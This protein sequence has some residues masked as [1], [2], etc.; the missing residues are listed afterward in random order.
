MLPTPLCFF[1]LIILG[2]KLNSD[3]VCPMR[4]WT[5]SMRQWTHVLLLF[6]GVAGIAILVAQRLQ[7]RHKEKQRMENVHVGMTKTEVIA[8]MGPGAMNR[9]EWMIDRPDGSSLRMTN[10]MT[11]PVNKGHTTF[12]VVFDDDDI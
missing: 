10:W 6:A 2:G 11:W 9:E 7:E 1:P 12:I 8:L 4:F 5:V 3:E